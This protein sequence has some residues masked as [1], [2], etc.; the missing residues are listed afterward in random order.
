M[1]ILFLDDEKTRHLVADKRFADPEITLVHV[2]NY[3]QA[4]AVLDTVTEPFDLAHLDHDLIEQT[5]A[6]EKTGYD[7]ALHIVSMRP[8]RRPRKIIIHSHNEVG[9]MRMLFL[10]RDAG[11]DVSALAFEYV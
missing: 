8:E 11:C 6:V 4:V 9:T 10:L 5:A 7:V 3:K 1:K 2:Y